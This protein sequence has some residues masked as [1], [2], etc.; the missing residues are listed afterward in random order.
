MTRTSLQIK[1]IFVNGL[2]YC[3][4]H[5]SLITKVHSWLHLSIGRAV[6]SVQFSSISQFSRVRLFVTPWTAACQASL[7]I[8][9]SWSLFKLMSIKSVMP[10][11]HLIQSHEQ[12]E[13]EGLSFLEVSRSQEISKSRWAQEMLWSMTY[14]QK[15]YVSSWWMHLGASTHCVIFSY[16]TLH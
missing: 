12:Y 15:W 13:K 14:K 7:S 6:S 9:N 5:Y 3:A 8:T 1:S 10:S 11:N 16:L 2:N 4:N